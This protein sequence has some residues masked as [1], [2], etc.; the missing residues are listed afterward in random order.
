MAVTEAGVHIVGENKARGERAC[1]NREGE[2][3]G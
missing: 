2:G 3:H 1:R